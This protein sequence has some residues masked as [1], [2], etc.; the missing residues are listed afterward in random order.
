MYKKKKLNNFI[1]CILYTSCKISISNDDI[2]RI[3][4]NLYFM[5]FIKVFIS[6]FVKV[7]V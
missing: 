7:E 5:L 3:I 4:K 2:N 6:S 1:L